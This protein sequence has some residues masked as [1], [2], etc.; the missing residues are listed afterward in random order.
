[1]PKDGKQNTPKEALLRFLGL[2]NEVSAPGVSEFCT[3]GHK[4]GRG[5]VLILHAEQVGLWT[6]RREEVG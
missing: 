2:L 6:L 3:P 4:A 1:M 5:F